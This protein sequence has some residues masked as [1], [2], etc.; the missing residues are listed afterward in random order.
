MKRPRS[1]ENKDVFRWKTQLPASFPPPPESRFPRTT[2]EC[3]S[4]RG[5]SPSAAPRWHRR[6]RRVRH[7][8]TEFCSV[9][10]LSEE[11]VRAS[12]VTRPDERRCFS[13]RERCLQHSRGEERHCWAGALLRH[14]LP[15]VSHSARASSYSGPAPLLNVG[16]TPLSLPSLWGE[17]GLRFRAPWG[18]RFS[19]CLS[20]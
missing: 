20:F 3:Q 9:C 1:P 19:S 14:T 13:Y 10:G 11:R 15:S 2:H 5:R 18:Q 17:T 8:N 12:R 7:E 4:A 16:D 6:R